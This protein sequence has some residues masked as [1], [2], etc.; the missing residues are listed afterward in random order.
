MQWTELW[1]LIVSMGGLR[2]GYVPEPDV[3]CTIYVLTNCISEHTRLYTTAPVHTTF[4]SLGLLN[5]VL[6]VWH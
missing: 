1:G 6:L 4:S 2:P 5:T 3:C